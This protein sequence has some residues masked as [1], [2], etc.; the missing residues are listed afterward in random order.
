MDD[1][2]IGGPVLSRTRRGRRLAVAAVCCGSI[3]AAMAG[4]GASRPGGGAGPSGGQPGRVELSY[5]LDGPRS[6]RVRVPVGTELV[7]TL[8]RAPGYAWSAVE[9]L[10]PAVVTVLRSGRGATVTAT[11]RAVAAGEAELRWTSSFTGDPFGPPTLLWRLA[12]TV[13][14]SAALAG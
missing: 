12:V 4:C 11:A 1:L 10:R 5:R 14:S 2:V 13:G 3:L 8:Q 7:I 6:N 9:S